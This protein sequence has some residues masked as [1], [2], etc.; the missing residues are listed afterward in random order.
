MSASLLPTSWRNGFLSTF[1][2]LR[3]FKF[4]RDKEA[5]CTCLEGKKT[6]RLHEIWDHVCTLIIGVL[7][8]FWVQ[9]WSAVLHSGVTQ[10]K[11]VWSTKQL[12]SILHVTCQGFTW[13]AS[14]WKRFTE[15]T[16]NTKYHLQDYVCSEQNDKGCVY[17][18]TPHTCDDRAPWMPLNSLHGEGCLYL[19]VN[20]M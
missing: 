16:L 6:A 7:T 4:K 10:A 12:R 17:H 14:Q 3:S 11:P 18:M 9:V 5:N 2:F 1:G 8:A 13:E 19:W 20:N 15:E